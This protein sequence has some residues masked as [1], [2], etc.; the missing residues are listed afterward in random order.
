MALGLKGHRSK[1]VR[2]MAGL[3]YTEIRRGFELY[4]CLL[5]IYRTTDIN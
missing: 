2:V 3:G 5:I 4:E 1:G